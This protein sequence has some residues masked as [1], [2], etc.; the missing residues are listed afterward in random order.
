MAV[1]VGHP[2]MSR[3]IQMAT[4]T[5]IEPILLGN[6]F[7]KACQYSARPISEIAAHTTDNGRHHS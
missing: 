7:G 2:A 4:F 6:S 1:S 5:P 3:P